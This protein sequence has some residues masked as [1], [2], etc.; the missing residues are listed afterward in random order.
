MGK[1]RLYVCLL[2]VVA[3]LSGCTM[4]SSEEMVNIQNKVGNLTSKIALLEERQASLE[5]SLL[6]L[7]TP[8]K[9][10]KVDM[11]SMSFTNEDIQTALK[12]AGFYSGPVDGSMGPGTDKAI[13]AFQRSNGLKA[14]G[15]AGAKTKSLLAKY[16]NASM[17]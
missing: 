15:I 5:E 7:T 2:A 11:S 13:K 6:K 10:Q 17:D 8:I 14:D 12:N 9:E 16:L 4:V 3:L 1:G